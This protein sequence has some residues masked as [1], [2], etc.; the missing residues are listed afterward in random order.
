MRIKL[1]RRITLVLSLLAVI[2][3][4]TGIR[5]LV[6][7]AHTGPNSPP[8]AGDDFITVHRSRSQDRVLL[9]NDS[10]PDGDT[11][12]I[13]T[14]GNFT[15]A[16]GQLFLVSSGGYVYTPVFGYVGTD[17]FV[18]T[19]CDQHGACTTA[20]I[21]FNVVNS[22]PVTAGETFTVHRSFS[23]DNALLPN[24]SDPDNDPITISP[25]GSTTGAHG[26]FFVNSSGGIVYN[27]TFGYIGSDSY[28]YTVCDNWAGCTNATVTFNV[29]N[30][31]P[32]TAD[33]TF[34]VHRSFSKD[35]A[36]LGN[37][38]DPDNDPITISPT[39]S[40]TGAHGT[41]FVNS[42]GGIVYNPT[43]GYIGSDSYTYTVCDN[44]A[45]CTN[46]TVTF[47]VV[48]TPPV[49]VDK[50]YFTHGSF[51][52]DNALLVGDSDPDNDPF[53]ISPAGP[54]PGPHGTLFLVSSGGFVY[55]PNAGFFGADTYTISVCDN[56]A[57]CSPQKVTFYN[58][59][60]DDG[61]NDGANPCDS[62]GEPV[63]VTNGNVWLQQ[64]DYHLSAIGFPIDVTRTYNSDSSRIG[65]FGRGWS[66]LLDQNIF[67]YDSNLVRL[68]DTDG[69]TTYFGRP[70]GSGGGL[71]A[72]QG[73]FYGQLSQSGGGFTLT[74][75]DGNVL[76]FD[77]SGKLLSLTDRNSNTT[78]LSYGANGFLASVTDPFARVL[79]VN[80]DANG[81]V[82]SISDTLG[83]IATYTYGASKQLLS[84]TYADNSAYNFAYDGNL[85]LTSVTDALGN[86]LESHTYD[87]QGRAITSERHGGVEHY[88]LNY[89]SSAETQVTDAMG[90]LSKYTIDRSKTRNVV[91][92]LEGV[93]G[94]GGGGS[95]VQTWTYDNQLNVT[96]KTDA[97]GHTI[98]YTYDGNGNI[99]TETDVTGTITHTYN[100]FSQELTRTNQLNGVTTNV[101]DT[102]GNRLTTTDA[103]NKDT[104]FTYDSHGLILTVTDARGKVTTFTYDTKGNR[105]QTVDAGGN[106]TLYFWDA[107]SR[108]TKLKDAS[109]RST[110]YGYDAAGRVN[111]ITHPDLSFVTFGYD[112]AGRRTTQTDERSNT[113][114]YA[115]DNAYRLTT[116]TDAANQ[117]TTLGYDVMSNQTSRTDALGRV[118][119]Y[120]YDDFNRLVK[121]IFPPASAGATR[122]FETIAYDAVGNVTQKTDAAGRVTSYGFD[123]ANRLTS[124][125]DAD[126]KTTSY[127]YDALSRIT[128]VLDP[129]SQNYQ[130]GYDAMSRVTQITRG[131][132]SMSYVYDAAGNRTQRTD[133]NGLVTNYTIDHLNRVSAITYPTRTVTYGY[134]FRNQVTS[135][136]NENGTVYIFYDNRYR[137]QTF[138]DPFFYG[139]QYTYDK[140]GNRTKLSVNGATYA[141]YTYDA[142]NRLT[143][144]KDGANLSFPQTYDAANRLLTRSAPNGVTSTYSYD[145]LDRITSLVHS[146]G[147]NVLIGNTYNYDNVSNISGWTNSSGSHSYVY[148][149]VDRLTS[150]T[151]SSQ[152]NEAYSY[153]AGGNRTSSALNGTYSYQ[154]VNKLT[155]TSA[156]SYSYDNNGNPVSRT[157]GSGT[158][159]F[160]W[161]EENRLTQVTLP[162][163]LVVNY[164]YDGLGR[165]IQRTTSAGAD[166]R[167]VYDDVDVT[168]DLN[169][170]WSV[171]TSYFN[172]PGV[173]DHL[174]QTSATTGVS[175]YLPDHLG[176]TAGLTS[177]TG[178]LTE[179]LN[180]DSFGN[181]P[182]SAFT[183]YTYSGRE[184]DP[185]TNLF[186]Y[187]ARFYDPSIG[188]FLNEDPIG[189]A[190]G[191]NAYSYVGNQPVDFIDPFGLQRLAPLGRNGQ[192]RRDVDRA[193]L[194]RLM[195]PRGSRGLP[196]DVKNNLN[197]G[198]IGLTSCY[199]GKNPAG[200]FYNLPEEAPGTQCFLEEG[201]AK[202]RRCPRCCRNTVFAKQ[203]QWKEEWGGHPPSPDPR[204]GRYP[205]DA[206]SNTGGL[207]NY[208]IWFPSTRSYAWMDHRIEDGP[209][210][211]SIA[212]LPVDDPHYPHTIWCST[213]V[214]NRGRR[215]R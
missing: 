25:T 8:I 28:T 154:S 59:G 118:I 26:T 4:L 171:A 117:A 162:S 65:P 85:R 60:N 180:Y 76:Q 202:A 97:L 12:S 184:R 10:D 48:N 90:R 34:T 40:T 58:V 188:R 42:S 7:H 99:L 29:V 89:V 213:C 20:T 92:R 194:E 198:C 96:A 70:V 186:H 72:L 51:S 189:M 174:R 84:V 137:V 199:I 139:L 176:S 135:A 146:S 88:T 67:V 136:A 98:S 112:L 141:T 175:Y 32:V 168:F 19:L 166:E 197:R 64:H 128:S 27:P 134:N 94:C 143:E 35:N 161:D 21:T 179:Q 56:W 101:Y 80:T 142:V 205:N 159:L 95:Q 122:L 11:I 158:T 195:T 23:K 6:V 196:E 41:F 113:T 203:G 82:L 178:T 55:T 81:Q 150:A 105:T 155:R 145:G 15:T 102:S 131:G 2:T 62:V 69:R 47:N 125:T 63:N 172:G 169:A 156:A 127:G 39:G 79:T 24:D 104:T 57:G 187:R 14:T 108:L 183:R 170:D 13:T 133:Y 16:H 45:G 54:Q 147:G 77:S 44:W 144:I 193:T 160:G 211:A 210:T 215:R 120:E 46:A 74:T 61:V 177:A 43:F 185:D 71:T 164:K 37:D 116:V 36:L 49:T 149:V 157:D 173:D 73:D 200:N 190:G 140:V 115:Y 123:N 192:N 124:S 50:V 109:S 110:L 129:L 83:T 5:F 148:D 204:T 31:P 209:Q 17:T 38:S 78:T 75:A 107:R 86:I 66:T 111:K 106:V 182:G 100:Q 52:Q 3:V 163:G 214:Q 212:S 165:R 132:V 138:S 126:T 206:I 151:H 119:N 91:T 33:E 130:F 22:P 18:Y 208:I 201:L 181:G 191:P 114:T 152:P 53:S 9:D 30:T 1:Y 121:T 87:G 207:F 93:C 153:D 167:Y 68:S 103:L